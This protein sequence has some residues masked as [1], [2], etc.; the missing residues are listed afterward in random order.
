MSSAVCGEGGCIKNFLFF[1]NLLF[2]INGDIRA[3]SV[4]LTDRM[5]YA[6]YSLQ[7]GNITGT[8]DHIFLSSENC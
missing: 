2:V 5:E 1:L 3:W 6:V 7:V 4:Q 8:K